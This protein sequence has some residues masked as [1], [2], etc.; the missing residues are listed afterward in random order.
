M[1]GPVCQTKSINNFSH[2]HHILQFNYIYYS[3]KQC[4]WYQCTVFFLIWL[5]QMLR[6]N[7]SGRQ[8]NAG[9]VGAN[10]KKS[11]QNPYAVI[12]K[13]WK[14]SSMMF[15]EKNVKSLRCE[16][17]AC[18]KPINANTHFFVFFFLVKFQC[19]F[20]IFIFNTIECDVAIVP[21]RL[22]NRYIR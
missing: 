21:W 12:N 19:V 18:I 6:R 3:S 16:G 13:R 15:A 5:R 8:V 22:T 1:A 10:G 14:W 7:W 20:F 11:Q 2:A 4:Y 17:A 9:R